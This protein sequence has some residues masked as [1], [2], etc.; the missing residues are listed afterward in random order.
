MPVGGLHTTNALHLFLLVLVTCIHLRSPTFLTGIKSRTKWLPRASSPNTM[1]TLPEDP[2]G[3][4]ADEERTPETGANNESRSPA[5]MLERVGLMNAVTQSLKSP[6]AAIWRRHW[7]GA[8]RLAAAWARKTKNDA[9]YL[10]CLYAP[11]VR[12]HSPG[13]GL[14]GV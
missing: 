13:L 12:Y 3:D 6:A 8:R 5:P 14:T 11:F 7:T 1:P 4:R 9:R 10:T 2:C